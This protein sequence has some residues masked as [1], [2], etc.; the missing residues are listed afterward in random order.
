M[1][2]SEVLFPAGSR[3]QER[4]KTTKRKTRAT[5]TEIPHTLAWCAQFIMLSCVLFFSWGCGQI[6]LK[7]TSTILSTPGSVEF[8][9]V[10]VGQ[11]ATAK[12]TLQNHGLSSAEISSLRT[13]TQLFSVTSPNALPATIPSGGTYTVTVAFAPA[14]AGAADG[15]L[16]VEFNAA[17]APTTTIGLSGT[18]IPGLSSLACN[19]TS[20]SGSGTDACSVK[21]NTPA[22]TDGLSVNLSSNNSGVVLPPGVT[23][24][25]NAISVGFS[26]SVSKI[27]SAQ[28]ATITAS[29]TGS[30]ASFALELMP[31]GPALTFDTSGIVFGNTTLNTPITQEVLASASGTLPVSISSA[32]V[33]GTNFKLA[34]A[35]FPVTLVP[36]QTAALNVEFNPSTLGNSTGQLT[37]TS[38][39]LAGGASTIPLSGTGVAYEVQLTWDPPSSDSDTITGYH[40]YRAT[41]GSSTYQL[42]GPAVVPR[43]TYT[44]ATVQG[45]SV[46]DYVVQSV[47]TSGKESPPSNTTTVTIP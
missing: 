19:L 13:N 8:G 22:G 7:T 42:L 38:N 5:S 10:V 17:A 30:S 35:T 14:S 15:Q 23:I 25:A 4:Y 34:G 33:N 9:A 36:G 3:S 11:S 28:S 1:G 46:Y 20:I 32:V 39:A 26:A 41:G 43:T 40:V 37:V 24:P 27:S 16:V 45:G 47:D 12:I 29:A 18:G 21:L 31:N 2:K 6:S 44:D